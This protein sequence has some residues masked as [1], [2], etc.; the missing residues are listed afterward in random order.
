MGG[1]APIKINTFWLKSKE[2]LLRAAFG[3]RAKSFEIIRSDKLTFLVLNAKLR[4]QTFR[5]EIDYL[6]LKRDFASFS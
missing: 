5:K 2:K 6:S 3:K 4:Y 1:I